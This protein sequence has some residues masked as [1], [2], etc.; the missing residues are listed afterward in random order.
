MNQYQKYFARKYLSNGYNVLVS[1]R[2]YFQCENCGFSSQGGHG[3]NALWIETI[4]DKRK[5]SHLIEIL[6]EI[7][8][9]FSVYVLM[10]CDCKYFYSDMICIMGNFPDIAKVFSGTSFEP[11]ILIS[12]DDLYLEDYNCYFLE[13]RSQ[14]EINL[15]NTTCTY[16]YWD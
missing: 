11:E 5:L 3:Q 15:K 9:T 1:Y 12:S 16:L 13:K 2:D 4:D 6:S 10:S 7:E 14:R 8:K